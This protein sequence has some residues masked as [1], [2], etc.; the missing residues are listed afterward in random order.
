MFNKCILNRKVHLNKVLPTRPRSVLTI[1]HRFLPTQ[2]MNLIRGT[3]A[4]KYFEFNF[5]TSPHYTAP[6]YTALH[7]TALH[8]TALRCNE[9]HCTALHNSFRWKLHLKLGNLGKLEKMI[10][11]SVVH[12]IH[13]ILKMHILCPYYI[14]WHALHCTKLYCTELHCT[15]LHNSFRWKL[16]LKWG[17]LGKLEKMNTISVVH[18]IHY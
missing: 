15:A 13:Y 11:I 1:F 9:P 5:G 18:F 12:Y 14:L 17:N 7:C 10:T 3:L 8:W 16:H 6:H 2:P 4:A